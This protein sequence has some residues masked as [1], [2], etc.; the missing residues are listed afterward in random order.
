[1]HIQTLKNMYKYYVS[2]RVCKNVKLGKIIYSLY[3]GIP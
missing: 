1:M 3:I 2:L